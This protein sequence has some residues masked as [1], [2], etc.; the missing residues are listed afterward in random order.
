MVDEDKMVTLVDILIH[1]KASR[2][3]KIL[4]SG[5]QQS[6]KDSVGSNC[7]LVKEL[8]KNEDVFAGRAFYS[9]WF[10]FSLISEFLF[11]EYSYFVQILVK[12]L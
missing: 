11:V 8:E 6:F 3:N 10:W 2:D 7:F 12:T 9:F 5:T 4:R 1:K